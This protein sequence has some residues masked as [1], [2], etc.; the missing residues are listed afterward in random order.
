MRKV[1]IKIFPLVIIYVV[2]F[3][4]FFR[5]LGNYFLQDDFFNI[6]RGWIWSLYPNFAFRPIP[7]ELFGSFVLHVL[8]KDPVLTHA[9]LLLFHFLNVYLLWVLIG[10]FTKKIR[11]Q[12]FMSFLYAVSSVHFGVIYWMSADY[13]LLGTTFLLLFLHTLFSYKS[14]PT[15]VKFLFLLF[16]YL[17]MVFTNEA[18]S[19]F[20]IFLFIIS[21]KEKAVGKLFTPVTL[22]C[23]FS[24]VLRVFLKTYSAGPDY[25]LGTLGETV[26]TIWWFI[27][28]SINVTE[29]IRFMGKAQIF[30]PIFFLLL[31]A[32]CMSVAGLV[33]LKTRKKP[34]RNI[35]LLGVVWFFLFG[36]PYF[37]LVHHVTS[38]Y[39][40][41]ALI[42]FIIVITYIWLPLFA[43]K[44]IRYI[45][46]ML[47][48][49]S[50]Y[51]MLSYINAGFLQKTSWLVWRAETARKYVRLA[52]QL[53]P[54]LPKGA[55]IVF[56]KTAVAHDEISLA[57]YNDIAF[58]LI[59]EDPSLNTI[60]DDN[61]I[62]KTGDVIISEVSIN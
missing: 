43:K 7:Y 59:Y 34:D 50:V 62:I 26:R 14:N 58:K 25:A 12:F 52:K 53:Y 3:I 51:G 13:I 41:C 23:V 18:F 8:G 29:G 1:L 31:L 39:L 16:L 54:V 15:K 4:I 10:R 17:C 40:N 21:T 2:S 5:G 60:Y 28:R 9:I 37:V 11:I 57:L 35:L 22:L 61:Y 55:T 20:P 30:L 45:F 24:I 48:F 33:F 47:L 46:L 38:Y 36:A 49:L 27:L 32:L 42:G 6:Y 56:G 19:V 44:Q